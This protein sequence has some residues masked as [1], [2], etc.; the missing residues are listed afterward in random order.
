MTI[1]Q[2]G[3]SAGW[4]VATPTNIETFAAQGGHKWPPPAIVPNYDRGIEK[5]PGDGSIAFSGYPFVPW[6]FGD[7]W[8]PLWYYLYNTINAGLYRGKVTINTLTVPGSLSYTRLN[9]W[10]YLPKPGKQV[11]S[12]GLIP[13]YTV[14]MTR[15]STPS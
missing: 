9:A 8:A 5:F 6:Y 10:M 11:T 14:Y 2:F 4:N 13:G 1:Y 12:F 7:F 15:L 3:L